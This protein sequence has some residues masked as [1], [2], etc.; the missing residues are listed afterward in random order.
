MY[1]THSTTRATWTTRTHAAQEGAQ[2]R[3]PRRLC[4]L[5]PRGDAIIIVV[6]TCGG[7]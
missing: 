1:G 7:Y 2:V 3:D 6:V 5:A 4:S